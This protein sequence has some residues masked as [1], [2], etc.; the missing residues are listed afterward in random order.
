MRRFQRSIQD[1]KQNFLFRV[2]NVVSRMRH[3]GSGRALSHEVHVDHALV[4]VL[5]GLH[6]DNPRDTCRGLRVD[7]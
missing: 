3:V 4:D 5:L 7:V 1:T 6:V 2:L